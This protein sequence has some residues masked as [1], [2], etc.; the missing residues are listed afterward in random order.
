[1]LKLMSCLYP[2]LRIEEL[3][4]PFRKGSKVALVGASREQ[5]A[6]GRGK[7]TQKA[8]NGAMQ[9][10]G[11]GRLEPKILPK[12]IDSAKCAGDITILHRLHDSI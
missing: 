1:M 11:R 6:R 9:G 7:G 3:Q 8:H 5:G 10:G 2:E 4:F 12:S